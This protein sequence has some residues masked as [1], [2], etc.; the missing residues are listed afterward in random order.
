MASDLSGVFVSEAG[1]CSV[2]MPH[3][4]LMRAPSEPIVE[5]EIGYRQ[6]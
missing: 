1:P 3:E 4:T 6:G 5:A 2:A